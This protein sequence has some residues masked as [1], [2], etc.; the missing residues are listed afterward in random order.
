MF[1]I[2]QMVLWLIGFLFDHFEPQKNWSVKIMG[3][4]N[5]FL[6]LKDNILSIHSVF[7]SWHAILLERQ[8]FLWTFF[9]EYTI[10]VV[11][12]VN[13]TVQTIY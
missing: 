7:F 3:I 9:M 4:Y 6:S 10:K 11:R 8:W 13:N 5:G 1:G 12:K 2:F